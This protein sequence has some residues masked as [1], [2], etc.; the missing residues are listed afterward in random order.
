MQSERV[1]AGDVL[2]RD[3]RVLVQQLPPLFVDGDGLFLLLRGPS[4]VA[5]LLGMLNQG[6][7]VVGMERVEDVEEVLPARVA[8]LR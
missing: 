5:L 4:G 6:L 3:E 1:S 2:T 7:D 8:A